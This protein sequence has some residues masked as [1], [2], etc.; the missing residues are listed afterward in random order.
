[1]KKVMLL[2]VLML[3]VVPA[4]SKAERSLPLWTYNAVEDTHSMYISG[5]MGDEIVS[6][7][8]GSTT[9]DAN[10]NWLFGFGMGFPTNRAHVEIGQSQ[11]D[12]YYIG[13]F[14]LEVGKDAGLFINGLLGAANF[15]E[16]CI[17][18]NEKTYTETTTREEGDVVT[19]EKSY[20]PPMYEAEKG[21]RNHTKILHGVGL[22]YFKPDSPLVVSVDYDNHRKFTGSVGL[23]WKF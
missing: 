2:I 1:M 19:T 11:I 18:Y 21:W 13:K 23:Y 3:L 7:E 22:T 12:N 9:L 17:G 10:W 4:T 20:D 6:I 8:I 16:R 5:G 14:G 15:R